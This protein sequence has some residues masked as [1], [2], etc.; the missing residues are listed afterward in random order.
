MAKVV[1]AGGPEAHRYLSKNNASIAR[2][3]LLAAAFPDSTVVVPVR[4]PWAQT[5]SL[6]GQHRRFK[7]LHAAQ[8]RFA[9]AYME[10]LG[11]F[12]FGEAFRPIAFGP[13]PPDPAA[14]DSPA[15]WL[16]YWAEAYEAVLETAGP[17]VVF[18]DYDRLAADPLPSLAALAAAI[19]VDAGDALRQAAARFRPSRPGTR[20]DAPGP[21]LDRAAR[22]HARLKARCLAPRPLE[23]V[24]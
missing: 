14:A 24:A 16:G 4:D 11:H 20:P 9:K 13:E 5:A 1:A 19:D 8:D 7:A 18:V 6:L 3:R 15:F 22:V 23:A 2:L 10:G 21:L 17:G 12:E